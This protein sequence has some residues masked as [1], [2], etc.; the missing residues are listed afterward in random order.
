M[1]S[2]NLLFLGDWGRRGHDDQ[3]RVAAGMGRA[4]NRLACAGVVTTGDNFYENGVLGTQD[5]HWRESF[6]DVYT[7]SS[8][9]VPWY[10]TLG[11]HDHRG[12]AEAQV[13]FS[14][15][16]RRWCMPGWHYTRTLAI[17]AHHN[18]QLIV[19]DTTPFVAIY[20]PGGCEWIDGITELSP[21]SQI[22]WLDHTLARSEARWK[23]VVGHHPMISGSP[24]HGSTVELDRLLRPRL[25]RYGVH[26]YISGHEH[27]LQHLQSDGIHHLVTGAGAQWRQTGEL[28]ETRFA[29][30]GLGFL[31]MSLTSTE[32]RFRFH[33]ADGAEIHEGSSTYRPDSAHCAA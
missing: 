20:R 24:M 23:L 22:A 11:N 31:S 25:E 14:R 2:L 5:S 26:A 10:A 29:Y 32:M 1:Q 7:A 3:R 19:L 16:D 6:N 17:D 15:H 8:L 30:P 21:T 33:D 12:R 18:V 28:P 4:A 13:Q 27:D 9:A